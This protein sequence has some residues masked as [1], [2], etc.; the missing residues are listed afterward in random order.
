MNLCKERRCQIEPFYLWAFK[1]Y[2]D[3]WAIVS[4]PLPVNCDKLKDFFVGLVTCILIT[5]PVVVL[6]P[7]RQIQ[8][9]WNCAKDKRCF[10]IAEK[11]SLLL[12]RII[13]ELNELKLPYK[14]KNRIMQDDPFQ[15]K[16]EFEGHCSLDF[17]HRDLTQL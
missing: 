10:S 1:Q 12:D 7:I 9:Y 3:F 15:A 5:V 8:F 6:F 2:R 13:H 4:N 16:E 17:Q 14:G 11:K